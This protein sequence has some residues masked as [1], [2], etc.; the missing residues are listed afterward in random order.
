MNQYKRRE[1]IDS[2]NLSMSEYNR[3]NENIIDT[4]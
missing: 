1:S 4:D 2:K 3:L